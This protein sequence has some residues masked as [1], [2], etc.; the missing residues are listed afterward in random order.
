MEAEAARRIVDAEAERNDALNELAG[1]EE[2]LECVW[3][4][5]SFLIVIF[6]LFYLIITVTVLD[7]FF[8]FFPVF[9]FVLVS[10]WTSNLYC[11]H[12]EHMHVHTSP[13]TH[14]LL[15]R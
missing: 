10:R 3:H 13:H 8:F 11:T 6:H 12:A 2:E 7:T 9:S 5:F 14:A 15:Q 1:A 4:S